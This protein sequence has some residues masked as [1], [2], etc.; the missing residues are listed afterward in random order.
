M[1]VVLIIC[2]DHPSKS[3]VHEKVPDADFAA[4]AMR[5]RDRA[6]SSDPVSAEKGKNRMDPDDGVK[7]ILED[8]E[9]EMTCPM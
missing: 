4:S 7:Q 2:I 5:N 9:D 3:A 1:T 6:R 8:F